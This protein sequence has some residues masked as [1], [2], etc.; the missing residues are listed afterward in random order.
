VVKKPHQIFFVGLTIP[1]IVW[2][3]KKW[4]Y[5]M[6]P[7][8]AKLALV[9]M[10]GFTSLMCP[11][12]TAYAVQPSSEKLK[13]LVPDTMYNG[14]VSVKPGSGWLALRKTKNHWV[15]TPT[16]LKIRKVYHDVAARYFAEFSSS[17]K[18]AIAFVRGSQFVAGRL[19]VPA[20]MN[21]DTGLNALSEGRQ[22]ADSGLL[23]I[24][25][26][27]GGSVYEFD[28]RKTKNPDGPPGV[29]PETYNHPIFVKSGQRETSIGEPGRGTGEGYVEVVWM[30][31]LD[32]DGKLDLILSVSENVSGG[33]CLLLSGSAKPKELF[34]PNLC[35]IGPPGC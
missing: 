18:D 35:H 32:R 22:S 2:R 16:T 15:L 20:L 28:V 6:T 17:H 31:D 21:Q 30:G 14:P 26:S 19:S 7:S 33:H 24:K 29:G 8:A 9:S 12:G 25:V 27:F 3:R 4:T 1:W 10:L 5:E 11:F 13:F 34:G 23:P